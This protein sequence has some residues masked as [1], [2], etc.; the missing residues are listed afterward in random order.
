MRVCA[1]VSILCV[2]VCVRVRARTLP[3]GGRICAH[4]LDTPPALIFFFLSCRRFY[5]LVLHVGAHER[6]VRYCSTA[7]SPARCQPTD[8]Q[9]AAEQRRMR[10]R[11]TRVNIIFIVFIIIVFGVART[12]ALSAWTWSWYLSTKCAHSTRVRGVQKTEPHVISVRNRH[13]RA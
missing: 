5:L 8:T 6:V 13:A 2:E 11:R 9:R 7:A 4:S 12:F 10:S 1:R 3:S